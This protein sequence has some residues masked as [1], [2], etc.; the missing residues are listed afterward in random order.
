[1]G[2]L[3][4]SVKS[5]KIRLGK[6]LLPSGW[7][8]HEVSWAM[9][10][11]VY[12]FGYINMVITSVAGVGVFWASKW[13]T[14]SLTHEDNLRICLIFIRIFYFEVRTDDIIGCFSLMMCFLH[15][16]ECVFLC[17][18]CVPTWY[19][20]CILAHCSAIQGLVILISVYALLPDAWQQIPFQLDKISV[21]VLG[22]SYRLL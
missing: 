12:N 14:Q 2:L 11:S 22:S 15:W 5:H 6:V 3:F 16:M 4:L 10:C 18:S 17:Y 19:R 21:H 13:Q 20:Y 8:Y 9:Q 7:Q 1:M